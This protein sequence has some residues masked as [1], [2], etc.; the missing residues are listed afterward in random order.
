MNPSNPPR[1]VPLEQTRERVVADLCRAFAEEQVDADVLQE[2]LDLAQRATSLAE[3]T[4]LTADLPAARPNDVPAPFP[5]DATAVALPG[6]AAGSQL[7]V[8]VMGGAVRRGAWSP[9]PSLNVL[10]VMGGAELDFRDARMGPLTQVNIFAC[11]GGVEIVVPP[12]VRVEVNGIAL[13]GGFDHRAMSGST[14]PPGAPV[15]RIGGFALMGGVEVSVRL[16]SETAR[17][18]RDRIR[19]ER[20]DLRRQRKLNRGQ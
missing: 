8:A 12:G 3:L 18:A 1:P 6:Q 9:P 10:A 20:R 16:P 19:E 11:M 7:L 5:A 15:L 13:M 2:R 17:D 4:A 14:P